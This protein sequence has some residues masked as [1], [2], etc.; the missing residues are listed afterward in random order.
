MRKIPAAVAAGAVLVLMLVLGA[1]GSASSGHAAAAA[2]SAEANPA[3]SADITQAKA[4][5]AR[6]VT[7]TPLQQIHTLRVLFLESATGK[8]G[9]EVAATRARVFS[10]M[11]VAPAQ[12]T[13]FKNDALTA[14]ERGKVYTKAGARTYLEGTLPALL[15]KYQAAGGMSP[16]GTPGTAATATAPAGSPAPSPGKTGTNS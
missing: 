8:N 2:S 16:T 15:A 10:C 7:G 12:Q 6:C 13:A 11:G 14:A 1:C 5:V 4:D 9:L 3:V